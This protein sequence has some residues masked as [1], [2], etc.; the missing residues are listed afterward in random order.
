VE[1]LR[2]SD[3]NKNAVQFFEARCIVLHQFHS[4]SASYN[5]FSVAHYPKLGAQ[6]GDIVPQ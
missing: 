5:N 1:I 2:S 4:S 6:T 3:R